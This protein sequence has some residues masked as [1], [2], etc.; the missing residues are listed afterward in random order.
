MKFCREQSGIMKIMAD[1]VEDV[2]AFRVSQVTV[3]FMIEL[4]VNPIRGL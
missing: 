4:E 1:F 3:L 2:A